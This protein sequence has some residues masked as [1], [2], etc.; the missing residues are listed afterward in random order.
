MDKEPVKDPAACKVTVSWT[1]AGLRC[2][3]EELRM[4]CRR[5]DSVRWDLDSDRPGA[6]ITAI[7]FEGSNPNGPFAEL[8]TDRGPTVWQG[9][10][11]NGGPR[12]RFKYSIHVIDDSGVPVELDPYILDTDRP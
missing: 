7:V 10:S 1:K 12:G 6:R 3:P 8:G 9:S 11:S 4:D 5:G 2:E